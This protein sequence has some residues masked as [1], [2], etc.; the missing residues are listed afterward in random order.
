MANFVR[1]KKMDSDPLKIISN[2]LESYTSKSIIELESTGREP[3]LRFFC[4][5]T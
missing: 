2:L 3:W 4:A 1:P 5:H